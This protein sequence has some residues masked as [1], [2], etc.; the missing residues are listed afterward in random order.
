MG[1][2][3]WETPIVS[4]RQREESW[5]LPRIKLGPDPCHTHTQ[6]GGF[7]QQPHHRPCDL[8]FVAQ[9]WLTIFIIIEDREIHYYS[10]KEGPCHAS[11]LISLVCINLAKFTRPLVQSSQS[12]LN[13]PSKSVQCACALY[14]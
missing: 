4:Q 8:S 12:I 7:E 6:M 11:R 3:G 13:F 2:Q 10:D 9:V 1:C 14:T 5:K